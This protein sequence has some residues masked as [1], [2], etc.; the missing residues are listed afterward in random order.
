MHRSI[1]RFIGGAVLLVT[2]AACA[3]DSRVTAP[4][5]E[6]RSS[7]AASNEDQ[8]PEYDTWHPGEEQSLRVARQV[9][10]FG[11]FSFDE[12]GNMILY[13]KNPRDASAVGLARAILGP[14]HASQRGG[15]KREAARPEIIV[16]EAQFT[17]AALHRYRSRIEA[18]VFATPGV[19]FT[20]LDEQVNRLVI[21]ID[22]ARADEA[23]RTVELILSRR[24]VPREAV[25]F[26]MG[27]QYISEPTPP[28]EFGDPNC[29]PDPCATDPSACES[30][31]GQTTDPCRID[32]SSCEP[33]PC[34][35]GDA[36]C[37]P[38]YFEM[39]AA[40]ND[41]RGVVRPILG[42]TLVTN[43]PAN[44]F[45]A[46]G[47]LGFQVWYCPPS[48]LGGGACA[49]YHVVTSHQTGAYA[50]VADVRFYQPKS[51]AANDAVIGREAYDTRWHTH[52]FT[53]RIDGGTATSQ[54]SATL[55]CR[56]SDAALIRAQGPS[57]G[58]G[59]LVRPAN[60]PYSDGYDH[61]S[62]QFALNP[63]TY[64]G[65]RIAW[66]GVAEQY[67]TVTKIG[68]ATGWR[69]G[70]VLRKCIDKLR[71][72]YIVFRCQTEVEWSLSRSGDS[73]A[74]VF[75]YGSDGTAML[76]GLHS[77]GDPNRGY[78][79]PLANLRND[80]GL[81]NDNYVDFDVIR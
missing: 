37:S 45:P 64:F 75:K 32:P 39:F 78:Y 81:R 1:S 3:D 31:T 12:Q 49:Y 76:V 58:F 30:E 7:A 66:E 8:L 67:Q 22:R 73:G 59:Y 34:V 70:Q 44:A 48:T 26:E 60:P 65:I 69:T 56:R 20:D 2:L 24:G 9:P 79:A 19:Q 6:S 29:N 80:F 25:D 54:C 33:D 50:Q 43:V 72:G 51:D 41:L 71:D 38:G 47:T 42:G 17:F 14:Y 53:V 15:W 5:V 4:Q 40:N 13:M 10:G 36:W 46:P 62:A 21:G 16:R 63:S 11:G 55:K 18:E 57:H 74:P 68:A 77:A 27:L 28:C 35:A 23:R 61:G 52:P